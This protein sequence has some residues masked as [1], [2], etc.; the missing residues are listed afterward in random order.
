MRGLAGASGVS[1]S[2]NGSY[3]LV[4]EF[5]ASR[6]Q[7]FWLSGPKAFTSEVLVNLPGPPHN[8]KK[9]L[10]GDIWVSIKKN[11]I[12]ASGVKINENGKILKIISLGKYYN[13]TGTSEFQQRGK[14]FYIGSSVAD[15]IGILS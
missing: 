13:T 10:T 6:V 5:I 11:N 8:I 4:A 1:V 2:S 12:M 15:F 9:T 7:K 3:V 14:K